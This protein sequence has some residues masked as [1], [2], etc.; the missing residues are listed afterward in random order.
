ME[1]KKLMKPGIEAIFVF[2]SFMPPRFRSC[3][4]PCPTLS[5]ISPHIN[6]NRL[7]LIG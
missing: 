5:N 4:F 2:T 3:I 1:A 7:R 6:L